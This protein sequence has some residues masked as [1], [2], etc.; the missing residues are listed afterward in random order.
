[1]RNQIC[2]RC[3][4]AAGVHMLRCREFEALLSGGAVNV[5]APRSVGA[6]FRQDRGHRER[7]A[8][9]RSDAEALVRALFC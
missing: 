9:T 8:A 7:A 3:G 5:T 6:A 1:M 2:A 4:F